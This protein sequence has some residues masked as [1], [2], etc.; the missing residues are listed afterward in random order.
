M[1]AHESSG[2]R[3]EA[4]RMAQRH[5]Q[6]LEDEFG[7]SPDPQLTAF[8]DRLKQAAD[9]PAIDTTAPVPER[10]KEDGAASPGLPSRNAIAVLPF[11]NLS[12]A[13]DVDPF[14]AGLHDD[15]LTELSRI[16]GLTV[17]ARTSVLCYRDSRR[18]VGEITRE[19]GVGSVV[20]GAVQSCDGR[21]RVNVQLIDG[22]S[23][24]HLW[25]ERY[26]REL[27]TDSLFDIQSD[28]V[29]KIVGSLRSE[30]AAAPV[31]TP[32]AAVRPTADLEAYRLHAQGQ[33]QLQ[34]LTEASLR[35]AASYFREAI[36][37]DPGYALAWVGL[38]DALTAQVDYG[39]DHP[40]ETMA[41][42]EAAVRHALELRPGLAEAH[43]GL[44]KLLGIQ[45][46]GPAGIGELTRA[47]ELVPGYG[48][49]HDWLSWTWQCL[50]RHKEAL[51]SAR[52]AVELEPLL[53]EAVSNLAISN[54]ASGLVDQALVEARRTRELA[55]DWSTGAFYEGLV[56]YRLGRF[57]EARSVLQ[58]LVV[59]WVG[60]G[61]Q[62]ALALAC[63][64]GGD[65]A[66]ARRLL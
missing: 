17:I 20:E 54:M 26:D 46:K 10:R 45:R 32:P 37:R 53:R 28:L 66:R 29:E 64:G 24:G 15:L 12:G 14:A 9:P 7:T 49:A 3:A 5:V 65:T 25:A 40:D 39:Y 22:H 52:R 21:L 19:L 59:E 31:R 13:A 50:G 56:L 51:D 48:Q 55:P 42:A 16:G 36:Q 38:A 44:G 33:Q 60:P 23:E 18:P 43:A 27:S 63:V 2:N 6:L 11:A 41:E 47:V 58:G 35:Q 30:L 62:A 1:E 57:D 4:L 61:A 8:A 34:Q